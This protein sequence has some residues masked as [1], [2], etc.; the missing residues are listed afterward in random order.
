[1]NLPLTKNFGS[2]SKYVLTD[3]DNS[4][5]TKEYIFKG[6]NLMLVT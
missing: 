5:I 1:M 6:A 2:Q 3:K 4:A